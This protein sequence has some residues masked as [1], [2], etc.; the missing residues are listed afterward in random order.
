MIFMYIFIVSD[1]LVVLRHI[2]LEL[3]L[4]MFFDV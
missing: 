4:V 2:E 1:P 3:G